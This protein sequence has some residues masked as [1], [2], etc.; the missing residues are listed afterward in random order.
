MKTRI[1]AAPAVE[2]LNATG[3]KYYRQDRKAEYK[4]SPPGRAMSPALS[5]HAT[6]CTQVSPS[7]CSKCS[8]VSWCA[9]LVILTTL[10][11]EFHTDFY[12]Q[13]CILD[14]S[15]YMLILKSKYFTIIFLYSKLYILTLSVAEFD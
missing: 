12:M 9:K 6:R 10:S 11:L 2:G 4:A 3:W 5:H 7:L 14:C 15:L 13:F 1:Y 8:C